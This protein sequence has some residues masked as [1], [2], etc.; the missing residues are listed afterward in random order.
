MAV[1]LRLQRMGKKKQP[2]YKIVAADSRSP[3]DGKFIEAIGRYN[4][5]TNPSEI[6]LLEDRALYWLGVGAQPTDTVKNLLSRKGLILRQD[7]MKKKASPEKIDQEMEKFRMLQED[8]QKRLLEKQSV[9]KGSKKKSSAAEAKG[10]ASE[11]KPA[12]TPAES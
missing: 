8:K 5:R 12:E 4:P 7:L 1:K 6:S 10:A 11:E 2:V 9:K 3:R